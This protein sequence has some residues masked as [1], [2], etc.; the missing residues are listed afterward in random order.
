MKTD[1]DDNDND[2]NNDNDE[3]HKTRALTRQEV[4][5]QPWLGDHQESTPCELDRC[6]HAVVSLPVLG[7]CWGPRLF[8]QQAPR[9]R[10]HRLHSQV[11]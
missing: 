9:G 6:L 5:V 8:G 7:A 2:D 10:N 11:C 3:Y 1:D 4:E